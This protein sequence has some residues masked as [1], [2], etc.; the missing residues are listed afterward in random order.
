MKLSEAI[1][2]GSIGTKQCRILL[3]DGDATCA[4]G[5]ALI[6]AGYTITNE[7]DAY[8]EFNR[9]FPIQS[10]LVECPAGGCG[11]DVREWP[12]GDILFHLNDSH[13][14]ERPRIANW[15]AGIEAQQEQVKEVVKEQINEFVA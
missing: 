10:L 14:W 7:D 11:R 6:G 2:L 5:A 13:L 4:I 15:V 12:L 1:L 3:Q 8:V 9:L